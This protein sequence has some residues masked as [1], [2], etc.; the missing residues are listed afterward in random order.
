MQHVVLHGARGTR[1][2]FADRRLRV[3]FRGRAGTAGR[4]SEGLLNGT[5]DFPVIFGVACVS[6][7]NQSR[8]LAATESPKGLNSGG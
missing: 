1:Q 6:V 7:V 4:Q 8:N 3:P 5:V 2:R